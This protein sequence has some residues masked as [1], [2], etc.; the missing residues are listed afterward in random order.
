MSTARIA[1]ALFLAAALLY[2]ATL[3]AF[4]SP[5]GMSFTMLIDAGDAGNPLWFQAEHLLYPTTGAAWAGVWGLLGVRPHVSLQVLNALAGAATVALAFL[6][7]A[8]L[9]RPDVRSHAEGLP[10]HRRAAAL[11]ALGLAVSYGHWLHATDVEDQILS[12]MLLAL[13][14]WLLAEWLR[15]SD[16]GTRHWLLVAGVGVAQAGAVLIHLTAALWT[17]PALLAL[18]WARRWRNGAA[19]LLALAAATGIPYL[20]VGVFRFG[21]VWP[22]D[23]VGWF[24]SAPGH[25]VWG[26]FGLGNVWAAIRALVEAF[27][28][29]QGGARFGDLLHGQLN[30]ANLLAVTG[31]TVI[32]ALLLILAGTA[33][34]T[35]LRPR[36]AGE[37][38]TAAKLAAWASVYF[39]FNVYW[40]PEDVQFW[41]VVLLPLWGLVALL[42]ATSQR[43]RRAIR[44]TQYAVL[45]L[46]A[47]LFIVNLGTAF[48]PRR[49][50]ANN[51]GLQAA[52]CVGEHTAPTDLIV[53]PGWDWA[54]SYIPYFAQRR[55][56][57]LVDT[58]LIAA[59]G[60]P[61]AA[62]DL[63][64]DAIQENMAYGGRVYVV[65][66]F[67]LGETDTAWLR[68]TAGLSPDDL[69]RWA[70]QPAFQ[71]QDETVWELTRP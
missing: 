51:P 6:A 13:A 32:G 66:L 43:S 68:D 67:D 18:L 37:R 47:A 17:V 41:T 39:L 20:L 33:L 65:R 52:R 23:Y 28:Y 61:L 16:T 24:L 53:T 30:P 36:A 58:T 60:D 45:V 64:Y 71:C 57:S 11:G 10:Q 38:R 12:N 63:I 34:L 7:L 4:Y 25:G 14:F 3:T 1:T 50:Q 46:L 15:R 21:Y 9:L 19:Y 2:L 54:S 44:H 31:F 59:G 48:W 40:A 49:D 42:V 22:G 5:D 56:L 35:L 29:Q 27:V 8:A 69:A 70:R 62:H 26:R 55:V